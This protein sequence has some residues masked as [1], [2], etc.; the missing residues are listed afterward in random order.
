MSSFTILRNSGTDDAVSISVDPATV[1]NRPSLREHLITGLSPSGATFRIII[2]SHNHAGYF[3]S[4]PLVV[5][6]AAVPDT[7]VNAPSSLTTITSGT[8]LGVSYGP[9]TVS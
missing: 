3:D 1:Q 7:P 4:P 6:L 2:R 8:Q 5:V 9:L